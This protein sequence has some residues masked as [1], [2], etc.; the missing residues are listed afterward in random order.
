MSV[1][2]SVLVYMSLNSCRCHYVN[3][4]GN[5]EFDYKCVTVSVTVSVSVQVM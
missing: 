2:F 4:S 3:V 5:N 1:A